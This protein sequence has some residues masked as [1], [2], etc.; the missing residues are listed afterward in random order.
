MTPESDDLPLIISVDDHIL[1]P[2]DLW[3]R[4]LPPGM[5]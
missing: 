5:C 1:E 2:R 3:Q 4:Q